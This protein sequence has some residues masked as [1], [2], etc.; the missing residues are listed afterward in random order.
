MAPFK[1]SNL[2]RVEDMVSFF[3]FANV[4]QGLKTTKKTK[5][6]GTFIKK[7]IDV[8]WN[9]FFV[10]FSRF[11]SSV[12]TNIYKKCF[13]KANFYYNKLEIGK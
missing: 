6:F 8:T 10:T 9:L 12:H 5:S 7:K 13:S 4:C 3:L 1:R 2:W 11:S